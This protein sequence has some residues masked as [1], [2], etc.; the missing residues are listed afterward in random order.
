MQTATVNIDK[1]H[2]RY[3]VNKYNILTSV[4]S[5]KGLTIGPL[6]E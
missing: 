5:S 2:V 3:S 6:P 4:K 1:C